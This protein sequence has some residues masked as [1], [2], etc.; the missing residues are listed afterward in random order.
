[1]VGEPAEPHETPSLAGPRQL[2]HL[3]DAVVI[4]SSGLDLAAML[5]RIVHAAAELVGARYA[6]LGV[7]DPSRRELSEFI[8]VGIGDDERAAI[9][10][11]PRGHG[12]LGLLITEPKPLRLPD[13]QEHPNSG[14]FPPNHPSMTTFLG[15]PIVIRGE[16]FGNLYL[17][18]KRSGDA[19][20]DIDQ[21]LVVALAAAAGVAV[22]NARLHERTR[23]VDTMEDRDRI[24]RDLHDRVIQ[25]LFAV[26]LGLQGAERLATE[27]GLRDRLTSA[28]DIL[29]ETIR[30]IRSTIFELGAR[31]E[32]GSSTR[33]A[34]SDLVTEVIGSTGIEATVR[35][36]GPVDTVVVGP[37]V[38]HVEAVL[39]E[40]LAN[41]AK[42]AQATSVAIVVSTSDG[43][44]VLDLVDDGRGLRG[45]EGPPGHG[46]VNMRSRA[47]ER[48]GEFSIENRPGGGLHLR[49][50]APVT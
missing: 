35:F 18:D 50:S 46:L 25:R 12:L 17:C 41:V 23:A 10:S 9:G 4:I 16:V 42:H 43:R 6:A 29:D 36:E 47:I 27:P 34:L 5:E 7:L 2:R 21:E 13:L 14:G 1:M 15:V 49:W 3:L 26:G 40:G 20:T 31:P 22:E 45:E 11:L 8:T 24:A 37:V 28:I 32:E 30:E 33:Q 44:V 38:A 19:F 48:G 39:R